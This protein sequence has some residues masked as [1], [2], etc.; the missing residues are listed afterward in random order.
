AI[1]VQL[2]LPLWARSA[3][4]RGGLGD[5]SERLKHNLGGNEGG[6]TALGLMPFVTLPT[7]AATSGAMFSR[8]WPRTA[9]G[10]TGLFLPNS[11]WMPRKGRR[12]SGPPI[13]A[14]CGCR[15]RPHLDGGVRLGL[16]DAAPDVIPFV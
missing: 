3:E 15:K 5:I 1:D 11:R 14:C 16:N 13:R 12:P 6:R 10:K 8:R 2:V 7:A 9:W 4:D